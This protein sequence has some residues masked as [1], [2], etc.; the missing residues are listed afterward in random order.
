MKSP[1][2][3]APVRERLNRKPA[4]IILAVVLMSAAIFARPAGPG[5]E[6][7]VRAEPRPPQVAFEEGEPLSLTI[8]AIG[9][10]TGLGLA[11]LHQGRLDSS[12]LKK[13]PV[14]ITSAA[15]STLCRIGDIGVSLILGHRQWKQKPLVFARLN[16]LATGDTVIV[17]GRGQTMTFEV[18]RK[19]TVKPAEIWTVVDEEHSRCAQRKRPVI[20]LVTCAPYGFNWRRLLIFAVR[21]EV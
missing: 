4:G 2:V 8:P 12:E 6:T 3:I 7:V 13:S 15:R 17:V 5:K 18:Y 16:E 1:S 19:A 9:L 20:I 14:M 11:R 21:R 10:R